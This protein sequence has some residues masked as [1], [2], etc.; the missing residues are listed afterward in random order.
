MTDADPFANL[1]VCLWCGQHPHFNRE[2]NLVCCLVNDE[3]PIGGLD[4]SREDW[5]L[6]SGIDLKDPESPALIKKIIEVLQPA[7]NLDSEAKYF[8][9]VMQELHAKL[10]SG[11]TNV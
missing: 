11:V 9:G 5:N 1:S 7:A 4:F 2:D 10:V 6:I 3:C 8:I